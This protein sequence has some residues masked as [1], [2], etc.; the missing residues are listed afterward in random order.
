MLDLEPETEASVEIKEL[1][2]SLGHREDQGSQCP[3]AEEAGKGLGPGENR[4]MWLPAASSPSPLVS[5][6]FISPLGRRLA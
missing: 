3:G 6:S 2:V 5:S 4:A 1:Q